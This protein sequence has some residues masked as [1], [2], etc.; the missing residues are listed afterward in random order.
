[1]LVHFNMNH[2]NKNQNKTRIPILSNKVSE[3]K[4]KN[5]GK[6]HLQE[7]LYLV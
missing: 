1:M 3:A 5:N 6:I 4:G 2:K 7:W